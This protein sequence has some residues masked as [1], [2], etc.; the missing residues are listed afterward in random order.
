MN[1]L[2][3]IV[4][5]LIMTITLFCGSYAVAQQEDIIAHTLNNYFQHV[6]R[7]G[8]FTGRLLTADDLSDEQQYQRQKDRYLPDTEEPLG[9]I[10]A[11]LGMTSVTLF[12]D[13]A[14]VVFGE[15]MDPTNSDRSQIDDFVLLDDTSGTW[16]GQ[17][18]LYNFAA[19]YE[20]EGTFANPVPEPSALALLALG[21]SMLVRRRPAES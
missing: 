10:F 16:R 3:K 11:P 5:P 6:G 20:L 19:A 14:D 15:P 7:E 2:P 8:F 9:E 21:W 4:Q 17:V 1:T 13:E 18:Y 12:F